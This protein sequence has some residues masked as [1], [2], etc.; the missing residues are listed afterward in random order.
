MYGK[1]LAIPKWKMTA[2]I[3]T[4]QELLMSL[5]VTPSM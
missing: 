1:W 4:K 2:L 3:L 5:K